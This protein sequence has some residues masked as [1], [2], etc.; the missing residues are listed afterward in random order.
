MKRKGFT[1]IELLVVIAIIAILAAMLLPVLA[2]AREKA[3]RGVCI[4]N[5]K[6]IGLA[7]KMY[8][9]DYDE[10]FPYIAGAATSNETAYAYCLLLGRW[11]NGANPQ[12]RVCGNYLRNTGTLVCPS[13]PYDIKYMVDSDNLSAVFVPLIGVPGGANTVT[14]ISYAYGCALDEQANVESVLA[15][16]KMNNFASNALWAGTVGASTTKTLDP[17]LDSHGTDGINV[18]Y[19]G[20]QAGWVPADKSGLLPTA[21]LGGGGIAVIRNP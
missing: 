20:G 7:M 17:S 13:A 14:N 15:A 5:L 19:V 18:L 9:Q 8:A 21:R 11:Y 6:Q 2:K 4:S 10:S 16:D 12:K 3:R 1:L